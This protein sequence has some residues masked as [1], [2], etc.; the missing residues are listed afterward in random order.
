M[1]SADRFA[2]RSRTNSASRSFAASGAPRYARGGVYEQIARARTQCLYDLVWTSGSG[3]APFHAR[4]HQLLVSVGVPS[5]G[6]TTK[7]ELIAVRESLVGVL[8]S[9]D[10]PALDIGP[11]ELI[12]FVDDLT[13]PTTASGDDAV[14]YNPLDPIAHQ[15]IRRDI[16]LTVEETRW[17]S[18][19]APPTASR[20]PPSCRPI[21]CSGAP[22]A[23]ARCIP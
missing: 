2:F 1:T 21:L 11:V 16:E 19:P 22:A 12:A 8:R 18:R 10:V 9:L 4:H 13:S 15:A 20:P 7:D 6:S 23:R 5:S 17:R 3:G 14:D